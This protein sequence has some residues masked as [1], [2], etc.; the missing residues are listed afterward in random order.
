MI[1]QTSPP[2]SSEQGNN[3]I[4]GDFNLHISEN[5]GND[6]DSAIFIDICEAMGLYQHV[7]FPTHKGGNTLDLVL[8]EW[9]ERVKVNTVTT[10][11]YI[12]DHR[13]VIFTPNIKKQQQR[14][15]TI[16]LCKTKDITTEQLIGEFSAANVPLTD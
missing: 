16:H 12:S 14:A 15:E 6:I 7:H 5:G 9:S 8:S 10:G 3:K 11:P 13:A 4:V 2:S 1:S